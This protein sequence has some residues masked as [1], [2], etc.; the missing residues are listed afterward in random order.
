MYI[1]IYIY[2]IYTTAPVLETGYSLE[3]LLRGVL[4]V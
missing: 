4:E 2:I 1:Y 3:D